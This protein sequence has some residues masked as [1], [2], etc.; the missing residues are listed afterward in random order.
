MVSLFLL[1]PPWAL[2]AS[3]CRS[4]NDIEKENSVRVCSLV[5]SF[6]RDSDALAYCERRRMASEW[7]EY[8]RNPLLPLCERARREFS[9]L[10]D[11]ATGLQALKLDAF[12]E[13][14]DRACIV[15]P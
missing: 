6:L 7:K 4:P 12:L 9:I 8:C 10:K 11:D 5:D 14:I 15:V 2:V 3:S 13:R 1:M